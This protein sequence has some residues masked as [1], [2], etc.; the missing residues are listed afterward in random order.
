ML[1]EMLNIPLKLILGIELSSP[2]FSSLVEETL[3]L[4]LAAAPEIFAV[5][6]ALVA[7][8]SLQSVIING[9]N[10]SISAS[11]TFMSHSCCP[12][13]NVSNFICIF[14]WMGSNSN[15]FDCN[16]ILTFIATTNFRRESNFLG[17]LVDV[18]DFFIGTG[19]CF[20]F[21]FALFFFLMVPMQTLVSCLHQLMP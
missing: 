4:E 14:I 19:Y 16:A 9:K 12:Y 6:A 2:S 3:K 7:S 20:S 1:V 8:F 11:G 21:F 15:L 10:L 13:L 18:T 5:E 17:L